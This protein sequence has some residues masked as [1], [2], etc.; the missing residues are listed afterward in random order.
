M[1]L[2][3]GCSL[4]EWQRGG[5]PPP[6]S[7]QTAEST[8]QF[9]IWA[10]VAAL[11]VGVIVW[12][13]ILWASFAYR[14][15]DDELPPQTRYNIP[16]E[17]FY[18]VVPFVIIGALFF[19]EYN[20][21]NVA[22]QT[23]GDASVH[24]DVI[25]QK[26]AWTFN[27]ADADVYDKGLSAAGGVT[28]LPTL[29]LPVGERV[30]FRLHS[31]DVNHSFWVPAFYFK[32]DVIPGR[33]NSFEITPSVEGEYAG[34][35]AELCG[36]YH[37]SMLFNVDIVDRATYDAHLRELRQRG[38]TPVIKI[39]DVA[40]QSGQGGGATVESPPPGEGSINQ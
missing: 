18:T 9:W 4:A 11:V 13:L 33:V 10:W 14:K 28:Q 2:L 40:Y 34:K 6:A 32:M 30:E 37:S 36:T 22:K 39:D 12:G 3:A 24:I 23:T 15:T 27:Y 21:E 5:L 29:Y 8:G 16:I 1:V 19:W 35:C 26:W 17:A 20:T 25:G 31:P 7:D 38:Q